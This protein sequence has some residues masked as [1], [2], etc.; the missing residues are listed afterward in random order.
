M[1]IDPR[2]L[3]PRP[4]TEEVVEIALAE[5]DRVR[6][7]TAVRA[8]DLGTGSGVIAL[9]LATEGGRDHPALGVV[10]TDV[11][12]GALAVAAGNLAAL[13][14]RDPAAARRVRLA[15]GDWWSAVPG[16]LAGRIDLVV[17]NP[18]YV[19]LDEWDDLPPGVRQ[20]PAVALVA[21]DG[22]GGTPGFAALATIIGGAPKWLARPG[23][24]VVELAPRQAEAA[25][26][27][28]RDAGCAHAEVRAD[29]AGRPRTLVARW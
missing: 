7:G 20:E 8:L 22:P 28:A 3:I 21:P 12:P 10:A 14:R 23:S 16:D 29:L 4:E 19:G 6:P 11:D 25:R 5:L 9:S 1:G 17:S 18:P 13:A 27:A 26:S 24:L 2:V 15:A